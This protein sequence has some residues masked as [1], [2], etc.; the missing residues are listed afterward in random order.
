MKKLLTTTILTA[1][2]MMSTIPVYAVDITLPSLNNAE[3]ATV[4]AQGANMSVKIGTDS[5]VGTLNWDSYN[6]GQGY[7]VDYHF[8]AANQTALNKVINSGSDYMSYIYGQILSSGYS[9]TGKVILIN[10]NGILFGDTANINLNSFT[11]STFDGTFDEGS[12]TLELTRSSDSGD[13]KVYGNIYADRNVTLAASNI[14][15]YADSKIS[16]NVNNSSFP[17]SVKLV[18]SDGVNFV[19]TDESA[20]DSVDSIS[21]SS[22]TMYIHLRGEIE[23]GSIDV[24]NASAD[25][26]SYILT[27]DAVLK[28]TKAV[29]DDGGNISLVSAGEITLGGEFTADNDINISSGDTFLTYSDTTLNAGNNINLHSDGHI[30]LYG[31]L[32]AQ[33][34]IN[35][36]S[37]SYTNIN[38]A[39]L[40]ASNDIDIDTESYIYIDDSN[41]TANNIDININNSNSYSM[42]S[43]STLEAGNNINIT[44]NYYYDIVSNSTMTAGGDLNLDLYSANITGSTIE[45][46]N[47]NIELKTAEDLVFGGENSLSA[48]DTISLTSTS[49]SGDIKDY[50]ENSVLNLNGSKTEIAAGNDINLTLTG[51]SN[52][53]KALSAH[54]GNDLTINADALAIDYLEADSLQDGIGSVTITTTSGAVNAI[55]GS[56]II[57]ANDIT[58]NAYSDAYI[59]GDLTATSGNID[60]DAGAY[61]KINGNLSAAN[62]YIDIDTVDNAYIYGDLTAKNDINVD[63]YYSIISNATTE[64]GNINIHAD[65]NVYVEGAL[66]AESGNIDINADE[67]VNIYSGELTANNITANAGDEIVLSLSEITASENLELT[68]ASDINII[69]ENSLSGNT[70]SLTAT[71][72]DVYTND[73]YYGDPVLDLNGSA[74][75]IYAGNDIN[76]TLTGVSNSSNTLTATAENDLIINADLLNASINLTANGNGDGNGDITI[77]ASSGINGNDDVM[78]ATGDINIEAAYILADN[79]SADAG[80]DVT[81]DGGMQISVNNFDITSKNDVN[82]SADTISFYDSADI[83]ATSSININ[84]DSSLLHIANSN[85]DAGGDLSLNA[86]GYIY[87]DQDADLSGSTISL[88]S[89]DYVKNSE[90]YSLNLNNKSTTI[91]A[92]GDVDLT[93]TGVNN[94]DNPLTISAADIN[95]TADSLA[96]SDLSASSGYITLTTTDGGIS[97]S[98]ADISGYNSVSVVSNEDVSIDTSSLSSDTSYVQIIS[99]TSAEIKDTSLYGT[100]A[101]ITA[102]D[103]IAFKGSNSMQGYATGGYN[104][105]LTS[106]NG[107]IY[108]ATD[109]ILDLNNSATTISAGNDIDLTLTGVS[110]DSNALTANAG[111]DLTLNVDGVLDNI[112]SL[113]A[114]NGSISITASEGVKIDN[115]DILSAAKDIAI[116]SDTSFVA[117]DSDLT[118]TGGSIDIDAG[119]FANIYGDLTATS[120]NIDIDT[121]TNAIITGNLDAK[122]ITVN[123]S[124]EYIQVQGSDITATGN[125]ALTADTD[126]IFYNQVDTSD[127]SSTGNSLKGNTISLTTTSGDV[128]TKSSNSNV[129]DSESVLNLNESKTAINAGK[130]I[131]VNLTGVSD[132]DNKLSATAGN[133]KTIMIDSKLYKDPSQRNVNSAKNEIYEKL[134]ADPEEQPKITSSQEQ[135]T[136]INP[137]PKQP[138]VFDNEVNITYEQSSSKQSLNSGKGVEINDRRNRAR[139]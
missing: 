99:G 25:S 49:T 28:A 134:L 71:A 18:T 120:G 139:H 72:G 97:I 12:N 17:S 50:D 79:F 126:I 52:T 7:T 56:K 128:V 96:V 75:T 16:T 11:A 66:T 131:N 26:D 83:S 85:I 105:A 129:A 24:T 2:T 124:T 95:I 35:I 119:T 31:S 54:A 63:G 29:E 76:L 80:G 67:S 108:T 39:T 40:N 114:Q 130:D 137:L 104:A 109:A 127:Y 98:N 53:S 118:T 101:K 20:V 8:S 30:A 5:K 87:F 92:D 59:Y 117:I 44:N 133:S 110:I 115:N 57:A 78:T 15:T 74:T 48:G 58:I 22:S 81:I 93:L 106:T 36:S 90:G 121:G 10:P 37:D 89:G 9:D 32:E 112:S 55:S 51:V 38:T 27:S 46:T 43:D 1:F 116:K 19:Y 113:T 91:N 102:N 100:E 132:P 34:D 138:E 84:A 86:G 33:S 136:I 6:I 77:T 21:S 111:N 62:G 135:V 68:A 61:T 69:S 73:N 82:L 88:T 13:I 123:A 122:D 4:T 65:S 23:S 47:G 64:S 125:L 41:I 14:Y 103:D 42:I 45:A 70:I 94:T 60:I 3:N 107:S